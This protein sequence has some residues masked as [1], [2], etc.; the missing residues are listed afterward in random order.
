MTADLQHTDT[1]EQARLPTPR[2]SGLGVRV[3]YEPILDVARGIA[4][5][6]QAHARLNDP[7]ADPRGHEVTAVVVDASLRAFA[8]LPTNT[9]I[10]VPVPLEL[11]GH[12]AI[13]GLLAG[14][15]DLRGI[16]LDITDFD[17]SLVS[18]AEQAL[19]DYRRAGA[20]I[21]VGGGDSGQPELGSIIRLRPAIIRLGAAWTE[22]IDR[23]AHRR[24]AIEV[25]GQLAGQLDAWILADE[26]SSPAELRVLAQLGVPLA[27]GPFIGAAEPDWS[28]IDSGARTVLPPTMEAP[29]G[30]L[31]S[32]LQQAYM[33]D[34]LA[35]AQTV[36]PDASGFESVVVVDGQSRPVSVLQQGTFGRWEPID[37]LTVNVD[38]PVAD[39]AARA[40]ARPQAARFSPIACTDAAGRFVGILRIER[41][42]EHLVAEARGNGNG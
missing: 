14:H 26:V 22:G 21:A 23:H 3:V 20:L 29:D 39:A 1:P 17:S 30:A 27:R 8:S 11:V 42:M 18:Q 19:D 34:N 28:T 6:Y 10:S 24:E 2:G 41:L 36:L 32:L 13:R 38:T 35:A 33:T 4:T 9:F 31:R 16:V 7:A 5:G 15:G 37:V 12:P 40:M 25:T